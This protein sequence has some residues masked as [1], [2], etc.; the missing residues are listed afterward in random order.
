MSMYV[1]RE[2]LFRLGEDS[3]ITDQ[4]GQPVLHVDGKILSLGDRLILRDPAGR[5]V[6]QVRRKLAALRPTFEIAIGGKNVAEV[7]RHLLAPFG[8]RFTI[9]VH[10]AGD[11]QINGDLLSHEF[12]IDRD[13]QTVATI[14]R[15][16]LTVT[17]SYA[18]D[19]APGED[20]VL[21][22]ASVLAL[23]LAIDAEHD[24]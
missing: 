13:G 14:S 16:W 19:V 5:E 17:A 7:R 6:G 9:E 12:T 24:H 23:D 20:D 11:M 3:D 10:G 18:V 1:I 8:E 22:L 21:I 15:R 4:A 2:R